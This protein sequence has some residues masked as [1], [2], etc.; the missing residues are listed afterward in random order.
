MEELISYVPAELGILVATLWAMGYFIKNTNK[1]PDPYIP[2][3]LIV[4]G[5]AGAVSLQG[6]STLAILQGVVCAS[7]SVL[8]KNIVKQG[9][10]ILNSVSDKKDTE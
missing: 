5:I 2:F 4:L 7:V 6:F 3:I 10:E 1:I 8:G 9:A